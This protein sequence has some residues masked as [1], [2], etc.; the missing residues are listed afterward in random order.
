VFDAFHVL[1]FGG[2][3]VEGMLDPSDA[4]R[5]GSSFLFLLAGELIMLE[6]QL[7]QLLLLLRLQLLDGNLKL[8]YLPLQGFEFR[9]VE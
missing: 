1:W 3:G 5:H 2:D 8:S 9:F 6:L 7:S 4:S